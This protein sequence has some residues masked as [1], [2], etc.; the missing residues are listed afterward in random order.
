MSDP[1]KEGDE[2]EVEPPPPP[3]SELVKR[4]WPFL[5]DD[6]FLLVAGLGA[7]VVSSY[8]N[9][10][11]PKLLKAIIDNVSVVDGASLSAPTAG[12]KQ[13]RA[14]FVRAATIIGAG[15]VGSYFRTRCGVGGWLRLETRKHLGRVQRR[16]C[17]W[18][19]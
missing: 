15:S 14:S 13:H 1:G 2:E 4:L 5:R 17:R 7:L 12:P 6:A 9:A 19:W 3:S 11:T 16:V 18:D 8:S 10:M